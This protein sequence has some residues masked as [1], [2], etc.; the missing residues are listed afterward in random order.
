MFVY[1]V[2]RKMLGPKKDEVSNKFRILGDDPVYITSHTQLFG[3]SCD[4]CD[5]NSERTGF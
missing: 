2:L 4:T 1:Q 3:S 5:L